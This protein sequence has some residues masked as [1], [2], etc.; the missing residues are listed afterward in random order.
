MPKGLKLI[1]LL[2]GMMER[3]YDPGATNGDR[4]QT[5]SPL[6]FKYIKNL[7]PRFYCNYT[8]MNEVMVTPQRPWLASH[9]ETLQ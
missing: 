3:S 6:V 8:I 5:A 2:S 7:P 9:D 1:P 4:L